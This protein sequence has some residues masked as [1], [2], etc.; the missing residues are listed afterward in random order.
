MHVCKRMGPAQ[1]NNFSLHDF[2]DKISNISKAE[3]GESK[4]SD[5]EYQEYLR[6]KSNNLTQPSRNPNSLTTY[7]SRYVDSQSP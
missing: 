3:V 2:P 1:E 5:E 6:L 4:F 7:I